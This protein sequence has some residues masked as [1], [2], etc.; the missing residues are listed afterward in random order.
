MWLN[1]L[2]TVCN[3]TWWV[4]LQVIC[5]AFWVGFFVLWVLRCRIP[6]R[7]LNVVER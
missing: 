1:G 7:H 2:A 6:K 4:N 3:C 5:V